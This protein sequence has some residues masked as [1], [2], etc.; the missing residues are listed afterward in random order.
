[1]I[2]VIPLAILQDAA[3]AGWGIS[4]PFEFDLRSALARLAPSQLLKVRQQ[5]MNPR[6]ILSADGC[7]GPRI[8]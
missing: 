8:D 7:P 6:G 2:H 3:Y 1:M 4:E 5:A